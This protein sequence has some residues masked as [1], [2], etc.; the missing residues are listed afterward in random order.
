MRIDDYLIVFIVTLCIASTSSRVVATGWE[1]LHEDGETLSPTAGMA[2][3]DGALSLCNSQLKEY[4]REVHRLNEAMRVARRSGV[5]GGEGEIGRDGVKGG[6]GNTGDAGGADRSVWG[7]GKEK[8]KGGRIDKVKIDALRLAV[9]R[10]MKRP[11]AN[12][13]ERLKEMNELF[14][15]AISALEKIQGLTGGNLNPDWGEEFE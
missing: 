3:N 13:E 4:A 1:A 14:G 15:S 5:D 12:A 6:G 7:V 11:D 9:E 8:D 10:I 2:S